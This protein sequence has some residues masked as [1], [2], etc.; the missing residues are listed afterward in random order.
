MPSERQPF[1]Q[2]AIAPAGARVGDFAGSD[3]LYRRAD[4]GLHIEA[5]VEMIAALAV[6]IAAHF[7]HQAH[8]FMRLVLRLTPATSWSRCAMAGPRGASGAGF[9]AADDLDVVQAEGG[10]IGHEQR[11]ILASAMPRGEYRRTPPSAP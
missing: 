1:R 9:I 4:G 7:A 8:H 3:G 11:A 10:A 6:E 5:A 2:L